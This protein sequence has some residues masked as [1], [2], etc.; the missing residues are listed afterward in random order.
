[1]PH[2]GGLY[3]PE[4]VDKLARGLR[5]NSEGP[6][7]DLVCDSDMFN[8]VTEDI[9]EGLP[10]VYPERDWSS[11]M[12]KFRPEVVGPEGAILLDLD[13]IITGDLAPIEEACKGFSCVGL[14]DPYFHPQIC[15]TAMY[16]SHEKAPEIWGLW[17]SRR[18][19]DMKDER[20]FF[21][22]AFSEM[23]WLREHVKPDALFD[24]LVPGA[25][26]S[27]KVDL[28]KAH[29]R[30]NTICVYFHGSP[31]DKPHNIHQ[32]WIKENWK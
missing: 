17:Q 24:D 4:W 9:V 13:T 18:D 30:K 20:Y 8:G 1:M 27:W 3:T 16:V 6:T 23:Y 21:R 25:F 29:P 12:E 31:N 10:F 32:D 26:A 14:L 28:N 15:S 5:R 19:Q 22:G 2:S 7:L 11:N